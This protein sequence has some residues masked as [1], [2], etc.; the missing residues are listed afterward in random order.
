LEIEALKKNIAVLE[1]G[2]SEEQQNHAKELEELS[3]SLSAKLQKLQAQHK[4]TIE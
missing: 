3:A 1:K 4:R 2:L